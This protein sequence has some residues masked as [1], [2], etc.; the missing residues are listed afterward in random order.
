[1]N[2][3]DELDRILER[4]RVLGECVRGDP[5][6]EILLDL[7][8]AGSLKTSSVGSTT[9]VPQTTA[10][11]HIKLLERDGLVKCTG[12]HGDARLSIVSLTQA[13]RE[14]VERCLA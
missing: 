10:L 3:R 8:D 13:G 1:M 14:A 9:R 2:A 5:A 4:Q 7:A 6:W 11:R 12:G